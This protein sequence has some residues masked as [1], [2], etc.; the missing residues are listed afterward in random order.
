MLERGLQNKPNKMIGRYGYFQAYYPGPNL[1][2]LQLGLDLENPGGF[3]EFHAGFHGFM[4]TGGYH[5]HI[6]DKLLF[7]FMVEK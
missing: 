3:M 4:Q 1:R 5:F 2:L 7:C 6:F